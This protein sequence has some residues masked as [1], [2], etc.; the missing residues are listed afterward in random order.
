MTESPGW[1]A[2][3]GIHP[4]ELMKKLRVGPGRA[5]WEAIDAFDISCARLPSGWYLVIIV[6]DVVFPTNEEWFAELSSE[7]DVVRF[8]V[9]AEGGFPLAQ[10]F[11]AGTKRWELRPDSDEDVRVSGTPPEC[12]AAIRQNRL[13]A[14]PPDDDSNPISFEIL[15]DVCESLTGFRYDRLETLTEPFIHHNINY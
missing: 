6:H 2:A 8:L 3:K 9:S 7:G 4:R 5:D 10:G 14:Q 15:V 11:H 13:A 12:F 1:I